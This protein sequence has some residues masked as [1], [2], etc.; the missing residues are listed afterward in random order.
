MLK[1]KQAGTPMKAEA[2][3]VRPANV[4]NLLDALRRSIAAEKPPPAPPVS[5]RRKPPMPANTGRTQRGR[6]TKRA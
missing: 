6:T 2:P 3:A 4:I 5:E 1:S